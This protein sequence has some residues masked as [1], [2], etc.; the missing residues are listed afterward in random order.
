LK[1]MD[2]LHIIFD[3]RLYGRGIFIHSLPN[4]AL[5]FVIN[6]LILSNS[7]AQLFLPLYA[8]LFILFVLLAALPAKNIGREFHTIGYWGSTLFLIIS[9]LAETFVFISF[10]RGAFEHNITGLFG[11]GLLFS[12]STTALLIAILYVAVLGQRVCLREV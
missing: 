4:L 9:V 6:A 11:F 5:A 8:V 10:L 2:I 12:I 7:N 3:K 1:I